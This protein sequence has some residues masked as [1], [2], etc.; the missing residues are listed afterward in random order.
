MGW[1]LP[2]RDARLGNLGNVSETGVADGDGLVYD[3]GTDTWQP[4]SAGTSAGG[5]SPDHQ[6]PDPLEQ[7]T[8]LTSPPAGG[9]TWFT[10]PRAVHL[11]GT[12]F[13]GYVDG[14]G[15]ICVRSF[16]HTTRTVSPAT[17]LAANYQTN[18]H[19]NP[20]LHIRR[21]DRRVLVF[22][23]AHNDTALRMAVSTAPMS[24]ASFGT[25]VDLH[26]QLG[27]T[28]YTYTNPVELDDGTL[29]LFYRRD[30]G[31]NGERIA[32]STS[33]D[34]GAT[35]TA[36]TT[37]VQAGSRRCYVRVAG[38]GD[39][40][41]VAVT[42]G[43]PTHNPA[44]SLFHGYWQAGSW[45]TSDGT[46]RTLPLAPAD[47]TLVHAAADDTSW[48]WDVARD[49]I[50]GHPRIA[51]TAF[52][53]ASDHRYR[54]A[55]WTGTGWTTSEIAAGGGTI[56]T[57]TAEPHYSGGMALDH[58]R[59]AVVYT[60]EQDGTGWRIVRNTTTDGG[61]TWTRQPLTAAGSMQVRPVV[62][63]NSAPELRAL[64]MAGTYS[65][66]TSWSTGTSGSGHQPATVPDSGYGGGPSVIDGGDASG[67]GG[68]SIIDGG[69]A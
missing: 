41:D 55:R 64:W 22:W 44:V 43:H 45:R 56:H 57:G 63:R 53:T 28:R 37:L 23:S 21:S 59:P 58:D 33:T 15:S 46:V 11:D 18:D 36:A 47:L 65:T 19:A 6:H 1:K 51:Y 39:R 10:D 24:V 30:Q 68:I 40:I 67:P 8:T 52:P 20:S 35:W 61:A 66:F 42:D 29:W 32:Y 49:P 27:G 69:S 26:S 31:G 60:S 34:G 12:T 9:W 2:L 5:G 7:A 14:S 62:V 38:G 25:P 16:D 13:F 4:G 54:Y 3:A 50:T 17:V 48:V